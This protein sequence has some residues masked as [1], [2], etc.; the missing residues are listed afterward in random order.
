MNKNRNTMAGEPADNETAELFPVRTEENTTGILDSVLKNVV[1]ESTRRDIPVRIF[2]IPKPPVGKSAAIGSEPPPFTPGTPEASTEKTEKTEKTGRLERLNA[3]DDFVKQL[4][5]FT[6]PEPALAKAPQVKTRPDAETERTPQPETKPETKPQPQFAPSAN[7]SPETDSS[8]GGREPL[9]AP[10][11]VVKLVPP[12]SDLPEKEKTEEKNPLPIPSPEDKG[13]VETVVIERKYPTGILDLFNRK[14]DET[15]THS[16]QTHPLE[17][18]RMWNPADGMT[19]DIMKNIEATNEKAKYAREKSAEE[20]KGLQK[21]LEDL[22]LKRKNMVHF[23][24]GVGWV[25]KNSL[26]TVDIPLHY[27]QADY[28]EISRLDRKRD[29][30]KRA[31]I[32]HPAVLTERKERTKEIDGKISELNDSAKRIRQENRKKMRETPATYYHRGR[33]M[34]EYEIETKGLDNFSNA[35]KLY[36][37]AK[38]VLNAPGKFDDSNGWSN[39]AKGLG[40][41]LSNIDFW[42][43][44]MTEISRN[45]KVKEVLDKMNNNPTGADLETILKEDELMLLDAFFTYGEATASRLDD[46]SVGYQMGQG[47]AEG[48]SMAVQGVLTGGAA[49]IAT[50]GARKAILKWIAG[51]MKKGLIDKALKYPVKKKIIS[52]TATN[53]LYK[54]LA[55]G[56]NA[57]IKSTVATPLMPSTYVNVSRKMIEPKRDEQGN[58]VMGENGYPVLQSSNDAIWD[59]LLDSWIEN[60]AGESGKHLRGVLKFAGTDVIPGSKKALKDFGKKFMQ[61][62]PGEMYRVL[63]ENPVFKYIGKNV[64]GGVT[65]AVAEE[66]YAENLRALVGYPEALQD[67]EAVESLLVMLA[68]VCVAGVIDKS[69]SGARLKRNEKRRAESARA[70]EKQLVETGYSQQQAAALVHQMDK[71]SMSEILDEMI[72][73]VNHLART[74]PQKAG[75]VLTALS[76]YVKNKNL[77]SL[78]L[79]VLVEQNQTPARQKDTKKRIGENTEWIENT[80]LRPV[81]MDE[82]ELAVSRLQPSD[83]GIVLPPQPLAVDVPGKRN[84]GLKTGL[85][86]KQQ[87]RLMRNLRK[88]GKK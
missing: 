85:S 39:T 88:Q 12:P 58:V 54:G 53:G 4:G 46:L 86:E 74:N 2:D 11:P 6:Q 81:K 17:F 18:S 76:T 14:E 19:P 79:D 71:A 22:E 62:K 21:E 72:P 56:S 24:E 43:L 13:G 23:K 60:V 16:A 40:N 55:W 36:E 48:M 73:F 8:S 68:P 5:V 3:F 66:W 26:G 38:D 31:I 34:R 10:L 77:H 50:T 87:R 15:P 67:A 51:R 49:T 84:T 59:A 52:Q 61:S 75:E 65:E 27:S 25:M 20:L 45:L 41:K 78:Q 29:E 7:P 57:G 82:A 44:G 9:P 1:A 69:V 63:S 33:R 30:L 37:D 32:T 35:L 80:P 42:T 64:V 28:E 70:F 47:I 83:A